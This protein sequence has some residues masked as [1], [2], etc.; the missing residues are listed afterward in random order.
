MVAAATRALV[1]EDDLKMRTEIEDVLALLGHEH[2]W[3]ECQQEAYA[4]LQRQQYSYVLADLEI[5]ARPDSKVTRIEYGAEFIGQIQR[6]KGRGAVPVIV[7]T[8]HAVEGLNLSSHL[9]HLGVLEFITKPFSDRPMDRTLAKVIQEVLHRHRGMCPPGALPGEEPREFRGG[10]LAY[11]ATHVELCGIVLLE[12]DAIGHS[13]SVMQALRTPRTS[14][15][16]PHL[17][18]PRLARAVDPSGQLSENAIASC[19]HHL[20]GRFAHTMLE[21]ANVLVGR[22]GVIA[23]GNRGY[24]LAPWLGIESYDGPLIGAAS[25]HVPT[26]TGPGTQAGQSPTVLDCPAVT[27]HEPPTAPTVPGAA[28]PRPNDAP[29]FHLAPLPER[30]QWIWEQVLAGVKLER[31]MV[32]RH[33]G[34][35]EKQAKRELAALSARGLIEFRRKPHPGFY[36]LA[37]QQDA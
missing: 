18:G 29:Q 27:P 1:V 35:S 30:Q 13:W 36:V 19:V 2:D 7:M 20:R 34:I 4:L 8:A 23:N 26:I 24:H 28:I 11:Y 32:Q 15:L 14:G 16:L 17:S 10:S 5:P 6:L 22:E 12:C 3:A 33:F 31:A 21:R 25:A 37:Q 9:G